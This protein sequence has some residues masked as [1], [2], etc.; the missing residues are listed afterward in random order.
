MN[1]YLGL[2][3][4]GTFVKGVLADENGKILC[5]GKAPTGCEKGSDIMCENIASL[6]IGLQSR[7]GVRPVAAGVACAGMIS[8]DGTVIFAGNLGLKDYPL[9]VKLSAALNLPV[10]VVNDANAAA[11]GE[12]AFGA[13]KAYSDSVFITLGTGVGGG[14]IAGGK[15][16]A[17][18]FGVGAEIGHMVIRHGGERCTC[19]RR[20]CFEAYSSATALIRE[21]RRAMEDNPASKMWSCGGLDKVTGKTAFDFAASDPAAKKVVDGYIYDL[22][23]GIINLANLF[24]PQAVILGGGVAEQGDKLIAPLQ[25]KLDSKIFGGQAYAPVKIVKA[26]LGNLAGALGAAAVARIQN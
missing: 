16:F 4:G 20:G 7:A 23:C 12:A 2:D 19:G 10:T 24:R 14:I 9:K 25:E 3:I 18:G 11:L 13:G 21:T 1:Y 22:A 26:T 8:A 15:L 17:G 5:D 6:C